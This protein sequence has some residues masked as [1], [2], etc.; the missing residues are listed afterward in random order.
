METVL[1]KLSGELLKGSRSSSQRVDVAFVRSVAHNIKQ[2]DKTHRFH[3][4]VGGGN[5]F[6]GARDGASAGIRQPIADSV[7]MLATV[8]N[9]LL[10][11]EIFAS[12]GISSV[13]LNANPLPGIV[14]GCE[15]A[16][17]DEALKNNTLIIF[18]GGTGNPYVSTDTAAVIRGLQIGTQTIWKASNVDGVYDTDPAVNKDAHLIKTISYE[19]AL[20]R[21][22]HV[23]DMT[24]IALAQ[25]HKMVLRVFSIFIPD[26]LLTAAQ[27]KNF[28]ST[29]Q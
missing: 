18:T 24:A 25:E 7:G 21:K 15:Q 11:H 14:A 17:I 19:D 3:V 9:G 20:Q 12:A 29:I 4:V 23:M 5:F 22:L 16:L 1:L 10:L 2:L 8:M 13:V 27:D 28:G 6:R 26:A